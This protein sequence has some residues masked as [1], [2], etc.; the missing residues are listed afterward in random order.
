MGV[1]CEKLA[2]GDAEE[3]TFRGIDKGCERKQFCVEGGIDVTCSLWR[4]IACVLLLIGHMQYYSFVIQL[5]LQPGF[6]NISS[7]L[8]HWQN[9]SSDFPTT[10]SASSSSFP[11]SPCFA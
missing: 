1:S 9:L 5:N 6:L 4:L 11:P 8:M 2:W 7:S 10:Q 3:A